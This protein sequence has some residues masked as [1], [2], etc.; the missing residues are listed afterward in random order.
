MSSQFPPPG[1][2]PNPRLRPV[3]E[4]DSVARADSDGYLLQGY[5][6]FGYDDLDNLRLRAE[7][8]GSSQGLWRPAPDPDRLGISGGGAG[9]RWRR[10]HRRDV[11]DS[12]ID[13]PARADLQRGQ[14]A[15]DQA[16][17]GGPGSRDARRR[18]PVAGRSNPKGS[19][20]PCPGQPGRARSVLERGRQRRQFDRGGFGRSG[21]EARLRQPGTRIGRRCCSRATARR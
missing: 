1:S 6:D 4:W 11:A 17:R 10:H 2:T 8:R 9:A 15:G 20:Q 21:Q 12:G 18:R 19:L 14:R 7:R 3:E 16:G 5:D 13:Q